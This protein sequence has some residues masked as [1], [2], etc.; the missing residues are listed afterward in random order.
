MLYDRLKVFILLKR[1][2]FLNF[3]YEDMYSGNN[4]GNNLFVRHEA[5]GQDFEF[6]DDRF[7]IKARMEGSTYKPILH[8]SIAPLHND[9]LGNYVARARFYV[10]IRKFFYFNVLYMSSS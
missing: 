6:S 9:E 10:I 1:Q 3:S 8:L 5:N 4:K 2:Y 7:G